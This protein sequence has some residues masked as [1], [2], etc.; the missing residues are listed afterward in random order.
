M[1]RFLYRIIK[2]LRLILQTAKYNSCATFLK[3]KLGIWICTR[4]SNHVSSIRYIRKNRIWILWHSTIFSAV[5]YFDSDVI[6]MTVRFHRVDTI[7]CR[8]DVLR[9]LQSFYKNITTHSGYCPNKIVVT[10][11][12]YT[13]LTALFPKISLFKFNCIIH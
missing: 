11:I 7:E 1:L 6:F 8:Q 13:S 5:W 2:E 3:I 12:K 9:Q 10:V 4:Q